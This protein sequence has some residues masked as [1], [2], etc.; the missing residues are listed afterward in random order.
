VSAAALDGGF[1]RRATIKKS[2]GVIYLQSM[3][4]LRVLTSR[5]CAA[6]THTA[7]LAQAIEAA[8]PRPRAGA[9]ARQGT[10]GQWP[11]DHR[12]SAVAAGDAPNI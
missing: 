10:R 12:E 5:D 6:R 3:S 9:G 11:R 4:L 7:I 1:K 2:C 8:G